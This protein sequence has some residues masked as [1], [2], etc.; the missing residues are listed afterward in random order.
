MIRVIVFLV[1]LGALAL[2]AGWV[3]D[4]Q[5]SVTIVWLGRQITT[6]IGVMIW[7]FVAVAVLA[8]LA[9]S[10]VRALVRAP[11]AARARRSA[12]GCEPSRMVCSRWAPATTAPPRATPARPSAWLATSRWRC[13]STLSPPNCAAIAKAP[14]APSAPWRS[15]TRRG[16]SGCAVSSSR[17]SARATGPPRAGS[18]RSS[19]GRRRPCAWSARAVLE[20]RCADGDWAGALAALDRG[21]KAGLVDRGSLPPPARRIAHRRGA[22]ACRRRSRNRQGGR[23]RSRQAR[24]RPGA[25]RGAGRHVPGSGRRAA[26]RRPHRRGGVAQQPAPGP[27]RRLPESEAGRLRAPET[28]AHA[29]ARARDAGQQPGGRARTRHVPRSRRRILRSRAQRWRRSSPHRPSGS[30]P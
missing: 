17:R 25:G 29:Q 26:P 13:C 7:S 19:V 18:P 9:W 15:A 8:A 12:R 10:I 6:S 27:R 14:S 21:Q 28:R 3:A 11:H 30:Q 4:Q 22:G 23:A 2:A 20:L 24:P 16:S 1:I 5:G